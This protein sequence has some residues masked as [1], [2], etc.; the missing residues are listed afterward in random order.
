M[1]KCISAFLILSLCWL[2]AC[3]IAN[4]GMATPS[5]ST[6]LPVAEERPVTMLELA[7]PLNLAKAELSGLTWA[8]DWLILLPQY[9][10]RFDQHIFRLHKDTI[11][12]YLD[13]ANPA[14]LQP[15]TVQFDSA[16]LQTSIRGFEGFESITTA[17]HTAY[18]TIESHDA[19][20]MLGYL[21][22][23]EW[24]ADFSAINLDAGS[25]IEIKPQT[26]LDNYSDESILV[27]GQRIVTFYEANG[28]NVNPQ[29]QAHLFN[30][31]L[32]TD[33]TIPLPNLEYRVTD[34]GQP[35]ENGHFWVI[36]YHYPGDTGKLDPAEDALAAKHGEGASHAQSEVVER[37]VALQ[38]SENGIV[39][40]DQPPIQF[41]LSADGEARNWEGLAYLDGR[42]FL[43][44]T[45]QH[46]Q[47][48]LGFVAYP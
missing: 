17:G 1:R 2:N 46:P 23:A 32:Q 18:L 37:L 12:A 30:L 43:L 42:G 48:L 36:N 26:S 4:P 40:A 24:N 19:A 21:V 25:L 44:V 45:D 47:T 8:G 34:A 13:N 7:E 9:P 10:D 33:G 39:L 31:Q 5:A 11:L 38:F 3:S 27:F 41:A 20:G 15:E 16:G 35:D 29:P 14:P 28:A 6:P 22:S